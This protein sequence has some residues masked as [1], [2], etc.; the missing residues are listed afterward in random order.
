MA[1]EH[2]SHNQNSTECC[3]SSH[4]AIQV[5]NEDYPMAK[6]YKETC[7]SDL[8]F[9]RIQGIEMI[10]NSIR[11]GDILKQLL[12]CETFWIWSFKAV[13]YPGLNKELDYRPFL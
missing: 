1:K 10:K 7:H 8:S 9:L 6:H 12:Q 13:D 5:N 4:P 3:D 11:G 2:I